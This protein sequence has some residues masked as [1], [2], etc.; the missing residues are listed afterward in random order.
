LLKV[1]ELGQEI[2]FEKKGQGIVK[3]GIGLRVLCTEPSGIGSRVASVIWSARA[4]H[5]EVGVCSPQGR[6][7]NAGGKLTICRRVSWYFPADFD[8]VFVK[9][10]GFICYL[11][12]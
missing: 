7:K 6:A 2:V 1:N 9:T 10:S 12:R 3:P 4:I 5:S 8:D 11:R